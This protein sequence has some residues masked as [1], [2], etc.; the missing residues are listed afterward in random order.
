MPG[1]LPTTKKAQGRALQGLMSSN[2]ARPYLDAPS[3]STRIT[4]RICRHP[5]YTQHNPSHKL[6]STSSSEPETQN[7][8]LRRPI[9]ARRQHTKLTKLATATAHCQTVASRP[10]SMTVGFRQKTYTIYTRMVSYTHIEQCT[11]RHTRCES[12]QDR[13]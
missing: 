12:S 4:P 7:P 1:R 8:T 13:T 3:L 9:W 10:F 2:Q 5:Q 11:H 6:N